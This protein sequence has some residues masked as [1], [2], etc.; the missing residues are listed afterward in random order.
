MIS[1]MGIAPIYYDAFVTVDGVRSE[2]F[3]KGLLPGQSKTFAIDAGGAAPELTIECDR[4]VE[5]QK[6]EFD[7]D[8]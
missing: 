1:S 5:G 7:A 8:L 4:L 3:L 2:T 6:I